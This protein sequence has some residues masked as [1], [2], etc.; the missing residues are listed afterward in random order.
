MHA[1]T[2]LFKQLQQFFEQ[3]LSGRWRISDV[4]FDQPEMAP[5]ERGQRQRHREIVCGMFGGYTISIFSTV[6]EPPLGRIIAADRFGNT[7][8]GPIDETT[9]RRI[10]ALI[11]QPAQGTERLQH[12]N[13]Y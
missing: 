13:G 10:A 5:K 12:V 9:W 8:S 11:K 4:V 1:R 7:A 2:L 3:H 6:E